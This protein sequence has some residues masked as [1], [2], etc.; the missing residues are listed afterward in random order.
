MNDCNANCSIESLQ[1]PPRSFEV[2]CGWL[3]LAAPRKNRAA[4]LFAASPRPA[5]SAK[6]DVER[7]TGGAAAMIG[8]F[9]LTR[10]RPWLYRGAR[11]RSDELS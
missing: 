2:E 10:P 7:A 8:L 6:S 11:L 9:G 5:A 3:G 4:A 1:R